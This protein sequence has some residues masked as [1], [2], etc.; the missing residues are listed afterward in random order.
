[1]VTKQ[2]N[3]A[4]CLRSTPHYRRDAF[5]AGLE[6]IGFKVWSASEMRPGPGDAIICWNRYLAYEQALQRYERAGAL[7]I[8]AEN[9]YIGTD[10]SGHHLFAL[11]LNQHNGAGTWPEGGPERW[12]ALGMELRPWR[13][14]PSRGRI[15]VLCQRGFGSAGVAMPKTWPEDVEKRLRAQTHR[16]IYVRKH[17][18]P[19]DHGPGLIAE[20]TGCYCAVTWGS[21]SA[22]KAL[23]A[24]YPVIA[25]M[26]NWIGQPATA[27]SLYD[28]DACVSAPVDRRQ[29]MFERLAWAQWS[30]AEIASGEAFKRYLTLH[31]TRE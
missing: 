9:G 17:P 3:A 13:S 4:L 27:A 7:V 31:E 28:V 23:L 26:P 8:I 6:R 12:A 30:A 22:H 1:M 24:G 10:E 14:L 25:D 29:G 16:P 21:G 19:V 20:I 15:V 5:Q 2:R 18:G 11:S